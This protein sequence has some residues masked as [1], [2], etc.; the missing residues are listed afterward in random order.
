M[1]SRLMAFDNP[2]MRFLTRL[3]DLVLLNF[4]FIVTSLPIV[5]IG[6]ST[7]SL[8]SCCQKL[9]RGQTTRVTQTYFNT[10]KANFKQATQLF[11]PMA[12]LL[13]IFVLDGLLMI[14]QAGL[15]KY[16]GLA[17]LALFSFAW[18]AVFVLGFSYIGRY[19]DN[20]GRILKNCLG[21]VLNNFFRTVFVVF[22]NV[23]VV[24]LFFSTPDRMITGIY[25]FT[26]GGIAL[27]AYLNSIAVKKIFDWAENAQKNS[28]VIIK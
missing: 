15:F 7:V 19:E 26:F 18:L 21:L 24:Y 23:C 17:I 13:G 4:L 27:V 1:F 6:A 8:F 9:L 14:Q 25:I 2:V 5:T 10:F 12:V 11:L 16:L 20:L 22:M 3:T 28:E